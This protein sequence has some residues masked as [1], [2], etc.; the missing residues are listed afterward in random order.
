[1]KQVVV[2]AKH[3]DGFCL[4]P[5][6]Y[7][8]HSVK[9]SPWQGGNGDVVGE[10]AKA[11]REF[12][13]K[14][15][16]YLSPWDRHEPTYGDSPRYNEHYTNQ[17]RELLTGI[18]PDTALQAAHAHAGRLQTG[19]KFTVSPACLCSNISHVR[20]HGNT[21]LCYVVDDNFSAF[22]CTGENAN[23]AGIDYACSLGHYS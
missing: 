13:L 9:N 11:C 5:S 15:G 12:G 3:H 6:K 10:V 20:S 4:W 1:M 8:E 2:T 18:D 22:G 21:A 23:A 17:L 16:I 14:L 19:Q 7:T